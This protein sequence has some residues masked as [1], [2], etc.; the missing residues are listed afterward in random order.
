[1]V[2]AAI[3]VIYAVS[4]LY[5]GGLKYVLLPALLYAP[6]VILFATAKR[7]VAQ[8]VFTHME[9]GIFA[10]VM[11]GAAIAAFGLYKGFVTL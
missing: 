11:T 9:K 6:G 4:L 10:A 2:I 1:M 5:A 7:E 8:P 3:A